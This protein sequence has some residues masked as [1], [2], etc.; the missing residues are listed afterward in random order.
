[1]TDNFLYIWLFITFILNIFF[2]INTIHSKLEKKSEIYLFINTIFS[3]IY[4]ALSPIFLQNIGFEIL[5]YYVIIGISIFFCIILFF[6]RLKKKIK[7][8]TNMDCN[9]F[10]KNVK[11]SDRKK[12]MKYI[13]IIY[14]FFPLIF[15]SI[16]LLMDFVAISHASNGIILTCREGEFMNINDYNYVITDQS[17][18]KLYTGLCNTLN[19]NF[20]YVP[21]EISE[22]NSEKIPTRILEKMKEENIEKDFVTI[23]KYD[24]YYFFTVYGCMGIENFIYHENDYLGKVKDDISKIRK[25]NIST[26]EQK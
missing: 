10:K 5:T 16:F 2:F 26:T 9:I 15:Y 19:E 1:M 6:L 23:Y 20:K 14:A 24:A 3:C 12:K 21:Y 17:V 4:L 8:N 7:L 22:V 13:V 25:V 11:V 18:Q